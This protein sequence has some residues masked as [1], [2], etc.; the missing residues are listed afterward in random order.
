MA[1]LNPWSACN[2]TTA[3]NDFLTSNDLDLLA[4]TESWL[5]SDNDSKPHR[6]KKHEMLPSNYQ[7]I[8]IPRP[9]GRRGGGVAVIFKQ[10]ILVKVMDYS[11][12]RTNQFEYIICAVTI[13]KSVIRLIIVYRPDPTSVN[14]LN[15]KL[16][17]KQFEDFLNKYAI[18]TEEVIIT[19]DL[20]FHLDKI[21]NNNTK[22]LNCILEGLGLKQ[23]VKEP[24]HVAGHILDVLIMRSETTVLKELQ[25]RDPCLINDDGKLIKDHFAV[26]WS[27]DINKPKPGKKEIKYHDLK[28]INFAQLTEDVLGTDLCNISSCD[29]RSASD[30][31]DLYN[32]TLQTMLNKYA[33]MKEKT[34]IVRDNAQWYTKEI[35][36]S[37]HLRRQAERRF[38]RSRTESDYHLYRQQCNKTNWILRK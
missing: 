4:M 16:F 31:V 33:P 1:F 34:V 23:M 21:T 8:Y 7:M 5:Q 28:E 12:C 13:C 6:V 9:E 38:M 2:K 37:K 17:W 22:Q 25:I 11:K 3:I 27:L 24:T 15:V 35:T 20:N 26:H 32:S 36:A 29:Q 10:T 30:L 18:C 14:K 19:G